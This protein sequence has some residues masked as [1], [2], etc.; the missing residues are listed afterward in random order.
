MEENNELLD[1]T[2]DFLTE[3]AKVMDESI[4]LSKEVGSYLKE[5]IEVNKF[6][7]ANISRNTYLP[8]RKILKILNGDPNAK[9]LD[10]IK[11][12]NFLE[13]KVSINFV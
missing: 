13:V 11:V 1:F 4:K 7:I 9:I 6:D 12:A 2:N 3:D 10:I 5:I 8:E